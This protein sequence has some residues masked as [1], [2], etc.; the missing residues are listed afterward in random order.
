MNEEFIR[1]SEC[2]NLNIV[3]STRCVFCDNNFD[4]EKKPQETAS[5]AVPETAIDEIP[6]PD[7]VKEEKPSLPKIPD[8]SIPQVEPEKEDVVI[9]EAIGEA[10]FVKKFFMISLYSILVAVIHYFLNLLVSTISVRIDDP[11]VD[12]YP[13]TGDLNLYI[14]INAVS[15]ILGIPFAIAIGYLFG[16]I[17]RHYTSK[18]SSVVKWFS[19]AIILDLIINVGIAIALIYAFDALNHKDVLL[20]KI[21]GAAFI[22]IGVC[23][24]TLFIP[25]ISGS[26]LAFDK[27]DKIFFP[28]KYAEY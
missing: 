27:I 2:G 22:F 24:I 12:V 19:Y 4:T 7:E 23:V 21:T 3:G 8:I 15:V 1:C 20:L 25:L 9:S 17:I 5:S 28:K 6:T 10:S 16:K 13:L 18:T 14:G 11:N 26:F